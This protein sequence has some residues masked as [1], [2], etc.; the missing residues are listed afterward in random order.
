MRALIYAQILAATG[1]GLA[2]EHTFD[3]PVSQREAQIGHPLMSARSYLDRQTPGTRQ[4]ER[5]ELRCFLA[6]CQQSN[7]WHTSNHALRTVVSRG[8]FVFR[9]L[10]RAGRNQG[11]R[12]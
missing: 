5:D 6:G 3:E 4:A 9:V 10:R 12:R 2:V 1:V 11:R 7:C 8:V